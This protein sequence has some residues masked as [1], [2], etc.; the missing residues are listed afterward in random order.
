MEFHERMAIVHAGH[1]F[2]N[3]ISEEGV[4]DLISALALEP[5]ARVLDIACGAGELLVRLAERYGVSG[6]GVDVSSGALAQARQ[7]ARERVP[8]ADLRFVEQ[9][10]AQYQ[11]SD[12]EQFNAVCLVGASWIWNGYVGTLRALVEWLKPGGVMLFG[13]PYWKVE[14]PPVEYC[15]ADGNFAP[16]TFTTLAGICE[17]AQAEGLRLTYMVGSTDRDWDRYEMLQSLAADR[18]ARANPDHPE[19]DEFVEAD[20]HSKHLYLRWGRAVLGFAQFVFRRF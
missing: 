7:K 15:D 5:G 4:E 9:D 3:P 1:I 16:E 17:A 2:W 13:E 10:G 18:W 20:R 19:L 14:N 6:V 11:P 8:D 12:G